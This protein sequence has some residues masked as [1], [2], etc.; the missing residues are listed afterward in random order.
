MTNS[1][2][3]VRDHWTSLT[4]SLSVLSCIFL[5]SWCRRR[6]VNFWPSSSSKM[7]NIE[8]SSN[9]NKTRKRPSIHHKER[10]FIHGDLLFPQTYNYLLSVIRCAIC[11]AYPTPSLPSYH[12]YYSLDITG[13]SIVNHSKNPF[14]RGTRR[15][16]ELHTTLAHFPRTDLCLSWDFN[17]WVSLI[18]VSGVLHVRRLATLTESE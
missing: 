6:Q 8:C 17:Q 3:T 10:L 1:T 13:K 9:H 16:V 2:S 11:I 4:L 15:C 18:D 12:Q 14:Y 7:F 5:S